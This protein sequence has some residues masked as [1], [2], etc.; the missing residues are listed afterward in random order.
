M[1]ESQL[2][3]R[4]CPT[5]GAT[6]GTADLSCPSC[7]HSLIPPPPMPALAAVPNRSPGAVLNSRY[8]IQKELGQ[9]GM[10]KVYLALDETLKRTVVIK[11][12]LRHDDPLLAAQAVKERDYLAAVKHPNIVSIYDFF[13]ADG[14]GCIVMEHVTGK[15]LLELME[16]RNG[17]LDP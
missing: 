4:K 11:T 17:P 13:P 5:C 6:L 15:T 3:E 2:T 1:I 12:I 9:G 7:H 16:E 8:R 10:G 14:E